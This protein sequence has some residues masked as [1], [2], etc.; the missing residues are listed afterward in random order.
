[1]EFSR[2]PWNVTDLI[3]LKTARLLK[4]DYMMLKVDK[5]AYGKF[6]MKIL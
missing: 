2:V 5:N 4:Y 1:M 3:I 6:E